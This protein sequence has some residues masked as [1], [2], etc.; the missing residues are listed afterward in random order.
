MV[1]T[2]AISGKK[3]RFR[4]PQSIVKEMEELRI[5]ADDLKEIGKYTDIRVA[6]EE[7]N[8]RSILDIAGRSAADRDAII[9]LM[10]NRLYFSQTNNEFIRNLGQ[11][12]SWAQ[13][14]S[15]QVNN[16][17]DKIKNRIF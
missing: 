4:S 9:P 1:P 15:V 17:L 10:G 13:A 2:P 11:F 8:A 14:K 7:G 3:V 6:F 16:L 5:S 12:S